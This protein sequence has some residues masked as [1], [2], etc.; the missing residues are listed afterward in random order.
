MKASTAKMSGLALAGIVSAWALLPAAGGQ[1]QAM[2]MAV[3]PFGWG[4]VVVVH[5]ATALLLSWVIAEVVWAVFPKLRSRR[6]TPL[7]IAGS[8]TL[9]WW[10]AS[11]G[12]LVGEVADLAG[13]GYVGRLVV[14]VL[15]CVVLQL[16][17][18]LA[19]LAVTPNTMSSKRDPLAIAHLFALA[20][21]VAFVV[22]LAYVDSLI[23]DQTALAKKHCGNNHVERARNIVWRLCDLGST[24]CLWKLDVNG[25]GAAEE[26]SPLSARAILEQDRAE[27]TRKG[28]SLRSVKRTDW[29]QVQLA[30][31]LVSLGELDQA[32]S[33]IRPVAPRDARAAV[34]LAQIHQQRKEW[35]QGS[36]WFQ[37]ALELARSARSG[38][39]AEARLNTKIQVHAYNMLAHNARELDQYDLA[40]SY[41]L[42]ALERLPAHQAYYHHQLGRHYE[43]WGRPVKAVEHF[44]RAFHLDPQRY[45]KPDGVAIRVLSVGTPVGIFRPD[46]SNYE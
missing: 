20:L 1:R 29:Q 34:V 4:R 25:D 14:R 24:K 38:Q 2:N 42:D 7:W 19:I 26:Y 43:L 46:A 6:L 45:G 8:L 39:P 31:H 40:A 11:H 12:S 16:P 22:P 17:W 21:V 3:A 18:C 30:Q 32:E 10:T 35:Q 15:W 28:A 33:V 23:D 13:A 27:L 41:Y 44:S 36:H 9:A 5:V 37:S